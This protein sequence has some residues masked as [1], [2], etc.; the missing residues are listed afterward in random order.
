MLGAVVR[1]LNPP[2]TSQWPWPGIQ[3]IS[4]VGRE[5]AGHNWI[6]PWKEALPEVIDPPLPGQAAAKITGACCT[7]KRRL[8]NCCSRSSSYSWLL[9]YVYPCPIGTAHLLKHF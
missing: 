5:E 7:T 4:F 1:T 9:P 3:C 8:S 2:R 6:K